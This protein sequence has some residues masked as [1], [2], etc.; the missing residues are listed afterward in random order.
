MP[1]RW[2]SR[3]CVEWADAI[4]GPLRSDVTH[5]MD[6]L[7]DFIAGM[8]AGDFS[9]LASRFEGEP[10][11][12]RQWDEQGAFTAMPDVR[13]EALSCACFL[14]QVSVAMYLLS[15]GID[16]AAGDATGMNALHWAVNRGQ[17]EA[18]QLLL[19][20]GVDL[21]RRSMYDGTA[22]GTAVW[23]AVHE[24]RPAHRAIIELLLSAGARVADAGYPSGNEDIDALLRRH[25]ASAS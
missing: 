16:P 6:P 23:S 17:L 13:A 4:L 11:L 9:R 1:W 10:A 12:V 25:G 24:P 8:R 22:L 21:E 3:T 5:R 2:R 18:V 19:D 15:Q 7:Q 20:E 14:G